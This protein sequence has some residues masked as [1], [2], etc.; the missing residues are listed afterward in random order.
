MMAMHSINSQSVEDCF[1]QAEAELLEALFP[2]ESAPY[3]WNPA[4]P[5]TSAYFAELE[6]G[7]EFE[8]WS[9]EEIT[10]RTQRLF[11]Q[12]NSCFPPATPA[13]LRA[14]L[15]ESFAARVPAS[16]LDAIA[17]RAQQIV[18]TN[19]TKAQQLVQV[20]GDFLPN[21]AEEDLLVLARPLAYAMRDNP[22]AVEST[23]GGVR[24][25]D[26][27]ELSPIEQARL[28]MAIAGYALE[29]LHA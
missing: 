23:F 26:W 10:G 28:S 18:S 2:T 14:S 16:L 19:L 27:T 29:Q 6:Q 20:V 11:A 9:D 24:V 3:L 17:D 8:D 1:S 12:L 13:T 7:F 21:F 25:A 22:Q 4:D 15:S 5:C